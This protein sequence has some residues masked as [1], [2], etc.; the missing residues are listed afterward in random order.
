MSNNKLEEIYED[1]K[2][3][4]LLIG[5]SGGSASGKTTICEHIKLNLEKCTILGLD[6]Y[7]RVIIKIL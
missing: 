2:F 7:Y 1:T 5:V 6:N 4:P 3:S